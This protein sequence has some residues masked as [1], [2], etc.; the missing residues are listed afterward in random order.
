MAFTTFEKEELL[1][2]SKN[3][4]WAILKVNNGERDMF[5]IVDDKDGLTEFPVIYDNRLVAYD[6]PEWIPKYVKNK[7]AVLV[8]KGIIGYD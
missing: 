4:L 7:F 5:V 2:Q 1:W 3:E 6:H 8:R